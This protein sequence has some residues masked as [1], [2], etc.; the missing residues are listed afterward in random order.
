VKRQVLF[1]KTIH[2]ELT[3]VSKS[4]IPFITITP[5]YGATDPM[6]PSTSIVQ[7]CGFLFI[8][9]NTPGCPVFSLSKESLST[10]IREF[11]SM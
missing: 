5:E 10:E 3:Y 1:F 6:K 11:K 9:T 7:S 4:L 2:F 8:I